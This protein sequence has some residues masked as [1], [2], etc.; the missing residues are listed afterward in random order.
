MEK[1]IL[2]LADSRV[3]DGDGLTPC[4][5]EKLRQHIIKENG[6][7]MGNKVYV[8]A[9]EQYLTK[10]DIVYECKSQREISPIEAAE[11]FDMVVA[12]FADIFSIGGMQVLEELAG[13]IRQC[14]VPFFVL[15]CGVG[16]EKYEDVKDLAKKTGTTVC[17]LLDAIYENG[18]EVA[19]RGWIT[20]AFLDL[21]MQNTAVATGCPSFYRTGEN[22][23]IE[24]PAVSRQEFSVAFN[25]CDYPD[26][27]ICNTMRN[28]PKSKLIDQELFISEYFRY[29]GKKIEVLGYEILRKYGI[30]IL[31]YFSEGRVF[32]AIDIPTWQK[33]LKK[34]SFSYGSRIHGTVTALH[35][36]IPMKMICKVPRTKEMAEYLGIPY[37]ESYPE[38][39]DLYEEYSGLDFSELKRKYT[40]GFH[41]F[42]KFLEE[43]KISYNPEDNSYWRSKMEEQAWED[44][45]VWSKEEL[46]ILQ[47]Q[48]GKKAYMIH[49]ALYR[50][51]KKLGNLW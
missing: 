38:N 19:T 30:N 41:I 8:T 46:D 47:K 31:K 26:E 15:G 20:K 13:W 39:I 24:N 29:E 16:C 36:G 6:I 33:E 2:L 23:I 43:H 12:P 34:Y 14:R 18:G 48:I 49:Y 50:C 5:R 37:S 1:R 25:S 17:K 40:E 21:C 45:E 11:K 9:V 4:T 42:K 10:P 28:Y 32:P 51:K 44:F 7:N 35:A 27:L 22:C 3:A